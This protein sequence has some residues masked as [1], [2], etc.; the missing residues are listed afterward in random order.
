M[1]DIV[2]E[3]N[4]FESELKA[5]M[6]DFHENPELGFN[7]YRTSKIIYDYLKKIND[8][9]GHNFGDIAIKTIADVLKSIYASYPKCVC[10]SLMNLLGTHDT[11]RILTVLGDMERDTSDI[12]NSELAVKRLDKE[13]RENGIALQKLAAT[14]QYTVYG[15]PSVFYG[16]EA[17]LEGYHDPF[18]RK[19]FPW[20]RECTELVDFY[21]TLGKIRQEESVFTDG[22]FRVE[23]ACG[24]VIAY[25]RYGDGTNVTVVVN[26]TEKSIRYDVKN[27]TVDLLTGNEYTGTVCP[28]SA[29]VLK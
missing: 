17:G 13:S 10:D 28:C 9:Y 26:A 15:V 18:C 14:I 7:E 21:R 27:K 11:E 3:T 25:S 2:R 8:T 4:D 19:T 23:Y 1:F 16:D 29:V 12:P 24:G 6:H 5:L 22:E 20:G